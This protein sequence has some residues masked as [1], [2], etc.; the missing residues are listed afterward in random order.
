MT[1]HLDSSDLTRV[2]PGTTMGEFMR[3][4]WLP[5]LRSSEVVADGETALLFPPGDAAALAAALQHLQ[6]DPAL[7]ERLAAAAARRVADYTWDARARRIL[8]ALAG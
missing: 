4:Y 6:R 8:A 7:R 5:A 3:Q 2:G 1:T